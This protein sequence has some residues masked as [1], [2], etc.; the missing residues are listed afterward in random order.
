MKVTIPL[1]LLLL[2]AGAV[3][4]LLGTEAGREQR[5]A[6]LVKMGRKDANTLSSIEDSLD[7]AI[8]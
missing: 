5:D 2:L 3:G 4:Y 1:A 7:S 8:G 6:I